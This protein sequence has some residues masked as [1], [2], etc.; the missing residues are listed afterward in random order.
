MGNMA[1]FHCF[2]DEVVPG[3]GDGG[4][5]AH[6]ARIGPGPPVTQALV[7][8][9]GGK[10]VRTPAVADRHHRQL[11]AGQA[12][13]DDDPPAGLPEGTPGE[14]FLDV[15]GCFLERARDKDALSCRQAVGLHDPGPGRLRR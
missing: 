7:V 15:A 12:F 6:P 2:A 10:G 3:E 1:R 14:L 9:R 11:P 8:L 4:I 13:L 5:G